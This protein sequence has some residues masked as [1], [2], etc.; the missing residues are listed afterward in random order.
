MDS[1]SWHMLVIA[2]RFVRIVSVV[3]VTHEESH[4]GMI[5]PAA[6]AALRKGISA[7]LEESAVGLVASAVCEMCRSVWP[8]ASPSAC[9]GSACSR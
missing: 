8:L 3:S 6:S 2:V 9:L 5:N 4:I 7:R 1:I